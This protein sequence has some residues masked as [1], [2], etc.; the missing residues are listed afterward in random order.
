MPIRPP[1]VPPNPF[2][3][4]YAI[5][6]VS[7]LVLLSG[8]SVCL[9]DLSQVS[10]CVDYADNAVGVMKKF[11]DHIVSWGIAFCQEVFRRHPVGWR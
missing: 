3:I 11:G 9:F 7:L 4:F 5:T 10:A 8:F 2:S 6:G 1:H